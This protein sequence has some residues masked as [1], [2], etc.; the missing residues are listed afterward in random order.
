MLRVDTNVLL[1]TILDDDPDQ[2]RR[3]TTLLDGKRV[4][5]AKT[6]LLELAWV[7]RSRYG[8][9]RSK[10]LLAL[11]AIA[12]TQNI[13]VEDLVAVSRA[14]VLMEQGLDFADAIHLSSGQQL[15]GEFVSFDRALLRAAE[16]LGLSVREP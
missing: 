4:F 3:A 2:T 12:D 16:R 10:L 8:F 6:V 5:V 15:G 13:E 9:D 1:R 11:R 14:L 7:L